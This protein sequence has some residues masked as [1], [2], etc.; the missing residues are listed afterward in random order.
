LKRDEQDVQ[1]IIDQYFGISDLTDAE[2]RMIADASPGNALNGALASVVGDR[3][4]L[5]W[6]SFGHT[7]VDVNVYAFGP[8]SDQFRGNHDNTRIG[9]VLRSLLTK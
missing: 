5:D 7:G 8:G 4:S 3:T 2:V 6:T 1:A 9:Q